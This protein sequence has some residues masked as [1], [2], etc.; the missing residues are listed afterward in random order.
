[1]QKSQYRMSMVYPIPEATGNHAIGA[2]LLGKSRSDFMLE[3]ACREAEDDLVDKRVFMLGPEDFK[4][5]QAILD[6]PQ[7][8]NT[9]LQRL[10]ATRASWEK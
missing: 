3:T 6:A 2:N 7:D 10:M 4:K 5:F 9:K 8:A 1:M